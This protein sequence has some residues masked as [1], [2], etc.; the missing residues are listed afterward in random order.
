M[1]T[2]LNFIEIGHDNLNLTNTFYAH[3][4][5]KQFRR[6]KAGNKHLR[7]IAKKPLPMLIGF[8]TKTEDFPYNL[9]LFK[10]KFDPHDK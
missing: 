5:V 7:K 2:V 4:D 9:R 6:T 8:T 3:T 1:K 10:P